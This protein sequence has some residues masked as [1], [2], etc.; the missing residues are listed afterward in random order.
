[1]SYR[2]NDGQIGPSPIDGYV[3]V[4]D[5]YFPIYT[6]DGYNFGF[7]SSSGTI[8]DSAR[9][10]IFLPNRMAAPT[11]NP[12]NGVYLYADGY[13]DLYS[14]NSNGLVQSVGNSRSVM[15]LTADGYT[16]VPSAIYQS[17]IMEFIGSF[18][19]ISNGGV[20][21]PNISGYQ[22]TVYNGTTGGQSLGF[23]INGQPGTAVVVGNGKRAII[24]C[25]GTNIVR[26]TLDA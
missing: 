25:D 22:W 15:I 21:L 2:T 3:H 12:I 16:V 8:F 7:F 23:L 1:M 6:F 14:R 20:Y 9:G 26:V 13:G 24:Y 5:G 11:S 4:N 17:N 10:I 18:P 19:T